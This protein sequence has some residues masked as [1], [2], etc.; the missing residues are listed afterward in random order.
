[1][2]FREIIAVYS[3]NYT[4]SIDA[5]CKQNT[6]LLYVKEGGTSLFITTF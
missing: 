1:M 2:I 5:L 4:K 6:E 3:E